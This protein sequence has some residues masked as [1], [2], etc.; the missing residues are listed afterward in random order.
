MRESPPSTAI[1][2]PVTQLCSE[3]NSQS[4]AEAI[5]WGAPMR[6]RACIPADAL[7]IASFCSKLAVRG[8]RV[9]PG[10]TQFTRIPRAA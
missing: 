4:M 10:A 3:S 9:I 2:C 6:P 5:S 7:A 8:V 1:T